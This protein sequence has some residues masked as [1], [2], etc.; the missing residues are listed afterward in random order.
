MEKYLEAADTALNLA[1]ANGP[2][3]PLIKKRY[4]LKD[5]H[6]VK[7]T[8]ESVYPQAGRH[9]GAASARRP[10][11]AVTLYQF[12]P[13]DRGTYRFR[14]S[15]SGVSERRQAGH[16]SRRRRPD[17]DGG[18]RTTWSATST[19][20]PTSRPSSSSSI[21]WRR[22]AP[23]ASSPTDWRG[24]Q[25]VHKI[26][27]DKYE[28]PGLAVQWVEVEGPLHDTWPPASHRRI[29]GDLP[30]APAPVFNNRNRVEVVSK[31]PEADAERIL[32]D[33]ARRAFRRAVTDD[34]IKPFV[35][36]GQ[37]QAGR[38]ALVRAG[39]ARRPHGA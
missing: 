1:I 38:E 13:P 6:Q 20:R 39:G 26:G 10:G 27:A 3:P 8:T 36:A 2:Q 23:F 32:R 12:Y 28:G 15:A 17:A 34:D 35:D 30:Q 29:F 7:I 31:D 21:T 18:R 24:A 22:G 19:P 14:I 11:N 25:A 9:R 16:L 33:F 37:G 4:S 5:E